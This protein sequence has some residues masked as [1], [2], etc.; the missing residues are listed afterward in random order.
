MKKIIIILTI[1]LTNLIIGQ[2]NVS[3]IAGSANN[4][5]DQN[6]IDSIAKNLNLKGGE[7]IKVLTTFKINENGD[8]VDITARSI[9]TAFEQ[10]AIR[11]ISELPKF[12]PV[13]LNGEKRSIKYSLPIV[14][15][16]E[17][18]SEKK[19]RDRKEKRKTEKELKKQSKN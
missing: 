14:F 2:N 8:V 7:T 15:K 5:H 6:R 18:D 9:H 10:E 4:N 1:L 16:I 19:A 12:N 3:N 13:I 11:I 17:T